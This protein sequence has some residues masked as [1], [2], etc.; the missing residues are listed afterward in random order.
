MLFTSSAIVEAKSSSKVLKLLR[1]GNYFLFKMAFSRP[2][3][4]SINKRPISM[5]PCAFPDLFAF[6]L[7]SI[8]HPVQAI[9]I[10]TRGNTVYTNSHILD[11]NKDGGDLDD[12]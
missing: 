12:R 9:S 7:S 1:R 10:V 3:I 5:L 11:G 4:C 2:V 8:S 6:T